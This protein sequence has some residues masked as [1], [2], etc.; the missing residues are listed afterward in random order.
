MGGGGGGCYCIMIRVWCPMFPDGNYF[1]GWH[2]TKSIISMKYFSS[3]CPFPR[4][5][6]ITRVLKLSVVPRVLTGHPEI[7]RICYNWY[8]YR[9]RIGEDVTERWAIFS[10]HV[11]HRGVSLTRHTP[12]WRTC[13]LDVLLARHEEYSSPVGRY[14]VGSAQTFE[15]TATTFLLSV[16]NI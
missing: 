15:K 11:L 8:K 6:I 13:L 12:R 7:E 5:K 14:L 2:F 3:P 10:K 16:W 4:N 9:T 1:L